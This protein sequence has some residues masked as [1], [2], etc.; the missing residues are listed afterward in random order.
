MLYRATN[1]SQK[2]K[3]AGYELSILDAD[4][5]LLALARHPPRFA[6]RLARPLAQAGARSPRAKKGEGPRWARAFG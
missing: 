4:F 5:R 6:A 3:G 2:Q 1:H